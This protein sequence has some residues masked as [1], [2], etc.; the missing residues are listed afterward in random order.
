MLVA[1]DIGNTNIT[2]GFF[3]GN[4]LIGNYRMTTKVRRTSDEYGFMLSTFLDNAKLKKEEVDD[5]IISSVVPK[6]MHSFKNGVV[7]FI[8]IE[9]IVVGPG[10]RSGISVQLENP[11]SVGSDRIADCAGAFSEY[12]GPILV[13]D[14]GT[15]TTYDYI[16][17]NGCFKAGAISVGIES[18]A[19]AL[20]GHTSQLPEIEIKPPK[21][22]LAKS[23]K[24]EMQAGIFYQY[25]GGVEYTIKQFR[26]EIGHDFKVVAT[27]GLGR[28]VC[29]HT[30]MIDIYDPNLI[31][32]GL[33]VIYDKNKKSD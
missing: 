28:V 20:W 21:S 11:K 13:V 30:K 27:G 23:T 16:D 2:I 33:K 15:A 7:K 18:G 12:G 1:I 14:F 19:N 8:G 5:V 22:I 10:I 25:L 17:K 29:A 9:P 31:F 3:E 6:V 26:K 32:K 4:E 24:I